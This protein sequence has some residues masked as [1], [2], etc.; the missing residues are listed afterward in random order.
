MM[1]WALPLSLLAHGLLLWLLWLPWRFEPNRPAVPLEVALRGGEAGPAEGGGAGRLGR[2]GDSAAA[3]RSRGGAP[4]E[5]PA[6]IQRSPQPSQ[7]LSSQDTDKPMRPAAPTP[8]AAAKTSPLAPAQANRSSTIAAP[9][10]SRV[11]GHGEAKDGGQATLPAGSGKTGAGAEGDRGALYAPAYL[12]NPQPSYPE[13][14]RQQ[15]EE[16]VVLLKVRVGVNGRALAVELARSSGFRRLDQSALET[17]SRWRFAPAVRNG[18][19]IESTL[20]VPIRFQAGG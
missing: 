6:M 19:A 8:S 2:A 5:P 20:T 11:V 10:E 14:S 13:R 16:G 7:A 3:M 9:G 17:V 4:Q 1:R 15:G 12:E 18:A